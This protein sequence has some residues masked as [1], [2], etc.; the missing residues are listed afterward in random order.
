MMLN[1]ITPAATTA[2]T[3]LDRVKNGLGITDDAEDE[4]LEAM[5]NAATDQACVYMNVVQAEDGTRTI[6]LETLEEVFP[7][8]G[9]ETTVML[10]R[11]PVVSIESV[12]VDEDGT[13]V[14]P[15]EY[16]VKRTTGIA[17]RQPASYYG[18]WGM[19]L[20][21]TYVAG[22]LLPGDSGRNLPWD[23]EDAAVRLVKTARSSRTRDPLTKSEDVPGL[24]RTE[25]WVGAVGASAGPGGS[26]LPPDIASTLDF[27][28]RWVL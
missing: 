11:I 9:Y 1:V 20:T 14:D 6:G 5:I 10:S 27:H 22:W 12:T 3:T 8:C 13:L 2:L 17:F 16:M 28:R 18:W 26:S 15:A 24:F 23:I 4:Y 7:Y 25:Y 21:I 19:P